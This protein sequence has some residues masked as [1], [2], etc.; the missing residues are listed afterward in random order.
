[1]PIDGGRIVSYLEL[2]TSGYQ[3]AMSSAHNML[4]M[5]QSD[6]VGLGA[7]LDS[8]GAFSRGAGPSS[9]WA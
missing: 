7:K 2:D 1:M 8:L 4:L 5:L 3:D 6:S 9:P